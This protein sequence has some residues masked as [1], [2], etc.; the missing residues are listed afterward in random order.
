MTR[1][2]YMH[3]AF[4]S[5]PP[6]IFEQYGLARLQHN[7]WVYMEIR[8]GMPG[9]KKAGCIANDR[10]IK[11]LDQFGYTPVQHT[12]SL[13]RHETRD[14]IFSLIVDDFGVKYV[15]KKNAEHLRDSL[16][17]LYR[18]SE[19][20]TGSKFLGLQLD[21]DYKNRPVDILM[22]KYV[23][24]ALHKFQHAKPKHPQDSPHP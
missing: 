2:E 10:L 12:P 7:G 8:N 6:E 4:A 11:H 14:I 19:D 3:I 22:L 16:R 1:Y 23:G 17:T 15:G 20:W 9:L 24:D 21:W 13:W 18:V 5:I